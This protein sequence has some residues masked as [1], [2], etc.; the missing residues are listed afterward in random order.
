[1]DLDQLARLAGVGA[2]QLNR[3]SREHLGQTT[4]T[5]YR[6]LR[7]AKSL[8]LLQRSGLSLSEI[9]SA[10]GFTT[11]AHYANRFRERYGISPSKARRNSDVIPSL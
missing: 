7:L 10:T 3:L 5:Y 11:Q 1:L 8:E 6:C 9:A 2:R 4:I